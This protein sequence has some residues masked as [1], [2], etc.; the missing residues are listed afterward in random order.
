MAEMISANEAEFV[1]MPEPMA[2]IIAGNE[3]FEAPQR[4]S[5]PVWLEMMDEGGHTLRL[6][7]ARPDADGELWVLAPLRRG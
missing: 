6:I 4:G 1:P 3:D 7:V 5:Q 2:D